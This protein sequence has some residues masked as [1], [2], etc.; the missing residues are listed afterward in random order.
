M[1]LLAVRIEFDPENNGLYLKFREGKVKQTIE[2]GNGNPIVLADIGEDNK[3]LYIEIFA[4]N[5]DY[6][7]C[8]L[9]VN[10]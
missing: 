2:I 10:I 4:T 8:N 9:T 3:L 6:H 5:D 1:G 7:T